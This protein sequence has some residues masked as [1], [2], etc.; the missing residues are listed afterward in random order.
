MNIVFIVPM[1]TGLAVGDV[2]G[3][4]KKGGN[5]GYPTLQCFLHDDYFGFCFFV[6]L[7]IVLERRNDRQF[8]A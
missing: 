4:R 2:T 7:G 5:E 1:F 6:N 3:N 8:L